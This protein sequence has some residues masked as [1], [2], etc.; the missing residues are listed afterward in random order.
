MAHI[1]CAVYWFNPLVWVAA[2]RMRV[3]RELACDDRVISA[4]SKASDY[5]ANLLEVARSLRA[6]SYT[7][8]TAIAMARPSQLSGRL[9]A[10]LDSKRNRRSVTRRVAAGIGFT[11]IAVAVLLSV[12]TPG[13]QAATIS[14][15]F[16]LPTNEV[17]AAMNEAPMSFSATTTLAEPS[18]SLVKAAQIPAIGIVAS[19]AANSPANALGT[20]S[21]VTATL[22][23]LLQ[24]GS[25][26]TSGDGDNSSVSINNNDDNGRSPSWNV[27][28][29]R[30]GC[31]MEL[32]AEGKFTLRPDLS[33][34]E[35]IDRDGWFRVEETVG[36]N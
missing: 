29:S 26:W 17:P 13:A 30:P 16:S 7:S 21:G 12:I 25:C 11:T 10:V 4:G 6:P 15:S 2:Q 33:D 18:L 23:L 20:L 28:Y 3:E 24:D 22:P 27:R 14:E 5:A 1:A 9:L 31:S 35:S 8:H 36:M 34:L 32:R 19:A